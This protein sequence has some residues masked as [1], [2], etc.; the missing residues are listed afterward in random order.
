MSGPARIRT[1]CFWRSRGA[2]RQAGG[3][4]DRGLLP[5][6]R[7]VYFSEVAKRAAAQL[8]MEMTQLERLNALA[9]AGNVT[10]E[11]ELL[12][13]LE[14]LRQRDQHQATAPAPTSE[15]A[16][17]GQEGSGEEGRGRGARAVRAAA[18]AVAAEA[19]SS[20]ELGRSR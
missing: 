2:E 12:K 16:E 7:K 3:N 5:T 10:A 9:E 11:K 1:R 4:G 14:K 6:L 19:L 20:D 17:A 13:Q 18:R 15:G 8:R